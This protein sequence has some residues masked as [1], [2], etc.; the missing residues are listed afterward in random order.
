MR[1]N[2]RIRERENDRFPIVFILEMSKPY[3]S[4]TYT[5]TRRHCWSCAVILLLSIFAGTHKSMLSDKIVCYSR[6]MIFTFVIITALYTKKKKKRLDR[7]YYRSHNSQVACCCTVSHEINLKLSLICQ[8]TSVLF[9]IE[10]S[11]LWHIKCSLRL[12]ITTAIFE[13]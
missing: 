7:C 5:T 10:N 11:L 4:A 13:F 6:F 9:L 1:E 3:C 8:H 2:Q 12:L